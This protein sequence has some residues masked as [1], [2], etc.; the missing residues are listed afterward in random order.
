MRRGDG[1][2]SRA[3]RREVVVA[4]QQRDRGRGRRTHRAAAAFNAA[5]VQRS[6]LTASRQTAGHLARRISLS[7]SAR[8]GT[9]AAASPSQ[10]ASG[11]GATRRSDRRGY[12]AARR[13]RLGAVTA[14]IRSSG[15]DSRGAR[16][17]AIKEP[18][19][20]WVVLDR[21]RKLLV[22]A[23]LEP[24]CGAVRLALGAELMRASAAPCRRRI[25]EGRRF[26]QAAVDRDASSRRSGGEERG[27][28]RNGAR[29]PGEANPAVRALS[30][31]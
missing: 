1:A 29:V 9:S 24:A 17:R 6:R 16:S 28:L 5:A 21:R 18:A 20:D 31:T 27:H 25:E 10:P 30:S 12:R 11:V 3:G 23:L 14:T 4:P 15:R 19:G 8:L 26:R 22:T 13:A 7:L 2:S